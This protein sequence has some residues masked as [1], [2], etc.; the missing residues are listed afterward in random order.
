[1]DRWRILVIDDHIDTL[2]LIR[3]TLMDDY[4]VLTLSEPLDFCEVL[5]L[6]EPDLIVLDIMMP[7]VTGFQIMEIMQRD[8]VHR[9]IPIIILS[10][11]DSTREIKYGYK[12]G[13][14]LY[15]TKP[16]QP[17]R[18]RKNV[19]ILFEHTPPARKP[20]QLTLPQVEMQ[21]KL[22][23]VYKVAIPG[24]GSPTP[25]PKEEEKQPRPKTSRRPSATPEE[26]R[27]WEG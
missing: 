18:L 9:D 16:F 24:P 7:K 12:L 14:R 20:K 3:M 8:A 26:E 2:E 10:A 5:R 27:R 22:K 19:Q 25:E 11:K 6:F 21:L 17:E 23:K 4:D 1:M 15:L 13:A